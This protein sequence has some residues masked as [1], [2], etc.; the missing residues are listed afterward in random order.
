MKSEKQIREALEENRIALVEFREYGE[1]TPDEHIFEGW[2]EA[3]EWVL[4][5]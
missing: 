2:V 1:E 3:L 4:N 5:K